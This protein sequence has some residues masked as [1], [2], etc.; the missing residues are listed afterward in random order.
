ML[1]FAK[2]AILLISL[3]VKSA[4]KDSPWKMENASSTRLAKREWLFLQESVTVL[5]ELIRIKMNNVFHAQTKIV[6]IAKTIYVQ[7][8]NQDTF[9][10]ENNAQDA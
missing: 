5:K 10:M 7:N 1:L 8:A 3:S 6:S 2:Y 9:L 4:L